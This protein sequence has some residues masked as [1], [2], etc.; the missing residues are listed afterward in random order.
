MLLLAPA[1]E[2]IIYDLV[3]GL[4]IIGRMG[5]QEIQQFWMDLISY[6]SIFTRLSIYLF[7]ALASLLPSSE[8]SQ[9]VLCSE[10]SLLIHFSNKRLLHFCK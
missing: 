4:D 10:I 3:T 6:L 8:I 1:V 9:S 5:R 2:E 7:T